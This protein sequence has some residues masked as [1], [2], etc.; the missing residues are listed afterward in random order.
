MWPVT[1][2]TNAAP[3]KQWRE[4]PKEQKEE[5]QRETKNTQSAS[6]MIESTNDAD[7]SAWWCRKVECGVSQAGRESN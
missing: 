7:R 4:T 1:A 6:G 2:A 5:T 3:T